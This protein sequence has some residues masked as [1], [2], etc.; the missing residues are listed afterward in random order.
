MELPRFG[1]SNLLAQTS[2]ETVDEWIRTDLNPKA[3]RAKQAAKKMLE[4]AVR[5]KG[6]EEIAGNSYFDPDLEQRRLHAVYR[7]IE[8]LLQTPD[9]CEVAR[10]RMNEHSRDW[11]KAG[12]VEPRYVNTK[13]NCSDMLTKAVSREDATV[14]G[15]MLS[16][17]QDLP[18]IPTAEDALQD[19]LKATD[20]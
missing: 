6:K 9:D 17:V 2:A 14:K 20:S 5:E 18:D 3:D 8:R 16:G 15:G 4:E 7:K 19:G 11:V 10:A 1:T 13:V 12:I